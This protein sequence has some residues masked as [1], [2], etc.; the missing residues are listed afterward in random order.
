MSSLQNSGNEDQVLQHSPRYMWAMESARMLEN[1][2]TSRVGGAGTLGLT[3]GN[4]EIAQRI[5]NICNSL[6]IT[7]LQNGIREVATTLLQRAFKVDLTLFELES[8]YQEQ[9]FAWKGRLLL[10]NL[11]AYVFLNS[12]QNQNSLKFVSESQKIATR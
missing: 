11:L 12:S 4:I 5:I 8:Q 10:M 3:I 1:R 2:L 7:C 6:A 9:I